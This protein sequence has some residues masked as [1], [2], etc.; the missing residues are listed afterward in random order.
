M[1]SPFSWPPRSLRPGAARDRLKI[2][3]QIAPAVPVTVQQASFTR[4]EGNYEVPAT[5]PAG[6][7]P[8]KGGL[9][10]GLSPR[11]AAPPPGL[12]RFFIEYPF[13]CLEQRVSIAAGLHDS[14]RW[15]DIAS[16]LPSY[17]DNDGLARYFPGEGSGSVTLTAYLLDIAAASEF[18]LPNEVRQRLLGVAVYDVG[19][20]QGELQSIRIPRHHPVHHVDLLERGRHGRLPL[21]R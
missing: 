12:K 3:Q 8:G 7:L 20:G 4:I 15:Q 14:Q 10:I 1:V 18:A 11:L 2:V 9:E 16:S 17:L 13:S 19:S 21:Q 5:L 6:A